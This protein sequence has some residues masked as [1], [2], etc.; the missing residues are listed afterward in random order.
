MVVEPTRGNTAARCHG[1]L[2]SGSKGETPTA[3]R[4]DTDHGARLGAVGRHELDAHCQVDQATS[5]RW[6][7]TVRTAG[8]ETH[9][10]GITLPS[11]SLTL[12]CT[13]NGGVSGGHPCGQ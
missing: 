4:S 11:L 2:R 6:V 10:V 7:T 1:L 13:I 8:A 9:S 5:E 12:S 3:G